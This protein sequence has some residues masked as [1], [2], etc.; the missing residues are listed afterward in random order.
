M[1]KFFYFLTVLLLPILSFGQLPWLEDFQSHVDPSGV[2][3][4]T[5][6]IVVNVGDYPAT[7]PWVIDATGASL[8]AN[9]DYGYVTGGQF[10]ARDTDGPLVFTTENINISTCTSV[11]FSIDFSESGTFELSDYINVEYSTDGGTNFTLITNWMG[12]GTL[13]NT[14]IDDFAPTTVTVTGLTGTSLVLRITFENN[15]GTELYMMDN[16]SV[17]GT[18]CSGGLTLNTGTVYGAPFFAD[19]GNGTSTSGDVDYTSTGTFNP[20]NIFNV[21]L[22]DENGSF[23]SP[24]T[25]GSLASTANTGNIVFNYPSD[26]PTGNNYIIRIVS[27]D[28]IVYGTNSTPFTI[29][30]TNPCGLTTGVVTGGPFQINC[31]NGITDAGTV[32]FNAVAVMQA[33]NVYTVEISD[34]FGSFTSPITIGTLTSTAN[35]GNIPITIPASLNSGTL[36]RVRISSSNPAMNSDSSAFFSVTQMQPCTPVLPTSNGLIINEFS[37]GPTGTA[38]E[39]YEFVVAGKCGDL[40]DIRGFILDDNNGTFTTPPVFPLTGSGVATGHFRFSNDP[41]WASIPVGS[42]IVI[43]NACDRNPL[44]PP[45]DPNDTSPN[46]SLYVVPHTSPLFEVCTQR[47]IAPSD[48]T[49]SPCTYSTASSACPTTIGSWG[50]LGLRNA[51]DAIQ[52]RTPA[53][54]YYHGVSYGGP[55]ISGGPHNLKLFTGSGSGMVGWFNSGDFFNISEWS[56]GGAPVAETPGLPNNAANLAWLKLMRDSL[57]LNCPVSILP[58]ELA[59]FEGEFNGYDANELTWLTLSERNASHYIIER[60]I[61]GKQWENVN[62]QNAIGN[63]MTESSYYFSDKHFIE[64]KINYYRLN[65]TDFNGVNTIFNKRIIAIDNTKTENKNIVK[66]INILGQEISTEEKGVQIII[67]DDGTI[68]RVFKM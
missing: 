40:V 55:E 36:F 29:T 7:T 2:E 8:T 18:G 26:L 27:T 14:I 47:P 12:L 16:I 34:E 65:Q 58:V 41:Q 3:G 62:Y 28:P 53:G 48:S 4:S 13:T 54:D 25:I 24:I 23:A 19:C 1:M 67:Y 5:G 63:T 22:S 32:P 46:D 64:G 59:K 38:Q 50:P 49:Y 6:G 33:G 42:L 43:Y 51:G 15:A 10:V 66:I 52:V 39:Y 37:N 56:S 57:N 45:D 21:E 61:D 68:E 30:Q 35:S 17:T 20:A 60:S 9:S 31:E 44:I 11:D